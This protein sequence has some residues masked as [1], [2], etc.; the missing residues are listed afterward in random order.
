MDGKN[1]R[2]EMS[3]APKPIMEVPEETA[4]IARAAF[5]KGNIYVRMRDRLG[6]FFVDEQFASLFSQRG[7]PAFSPWRLALVSI[8]QFA[9]DLSDRQAADAVRGRIDWK[10]LLGLE[11]ED[12]GFNYSV[13]SEFRQ[14]LLAGNLEQ[15]LLDT[16]LEVFA[17]DGLIKKR[18]MQRTDSTHVVAAVR[19][20]NR[21]ETI[22]ETMRSTL[23]LI[24]TIA[25]E[26]LQEFTPPE[27]YDRYGARVEEAKLPQKT[28]EK[29]AWI[30]AVAADGHYL[31]NS[32]YTSETH[33]WLWKMPAIRILWQVW[34]QHFHYLDGKLKLRDVKGLPPAS[35]RC[36]SP[37]DPEAHFSKKR[38][39]EWV[40]YKVHLTETCD[41]DKPN[42]IT[43]IETTIAPQSDA[44]MT[45]PVHEALA[46]K[47]CLPDTHLVDAGYVDAEQLVE[48]QDKYEITLLGPV[49]PKVNWQ[50]V[51]N[52]GY[53][54]ENFQIDWDAKMVTCPK[55][56]TSASWNPMVNTDGN[57]T[58]LA[59]FPGPACRDCEDR[60]LCT[61]RK[62]TP[63]TLT[64]HPQKQ[65]KALQQARQKQTTEEWQLQ[66]AK[67]AGVEG[68]ISQSVRGFGLRECRYVGLA[69][70]HLQHILTA[71]AI[72][73]VR[74]DDWFTGKK[75]AQTRVSRFAALRPVPV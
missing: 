59:R 2:F 27:W 70:T 32:I 65:H 48:S 17:E 49:R 50:T 1:R 15:H 53:A 63:R 18:G 23:N 25:P 41:D 69:K 16:M 29:E 7:Q 3:L 60:S 67:R 35:I 21:L 26:W 31:L 39:T 75:R 68:T 61:R 11:L 34:L 71:A 72:N 66:Y 8:L 45:E 33:H 6:V 14:R 9:E 62:T 74:L 64:L 46:A 13:L 36:D 12:P 20:L 47:D 24:A 73:L 57:Q 19:H 5:P 4:R 10:Y 44:N 22:G 56:I 54:A 30:A 52:T 38:S 55:G 51:Q 58:F 43:H 40:G 42:L 28:K 37:Y